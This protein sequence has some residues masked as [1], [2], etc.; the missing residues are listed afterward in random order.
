MIQK[1][2]DALERE[3]SNNIKKHNILKI[4]KNIGAIFT[5]SYLH[6]GEMPKKNNSWKKFCKRS[7]MNCLNNTYNY[8]TASDMYKKIRETEGERN[9]DR[10]YL[11]KEVL[12]RMKKDIKN[13]FKNKPFDI[14][15]KKKIINIVECILYFNWL[16][17]L[18][19]GLKILTPNA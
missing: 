15:Q 1:D 18:G 10:V 13:V 3:K 4:L 11:I 12:N 5:G 8:Q 16:E 14:E 6:Y 2:A 7:T 19:Q 17:Q 9:E